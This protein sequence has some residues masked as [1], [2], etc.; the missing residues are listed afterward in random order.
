[1]EGLDGAPLAH[2]GP[3]VDVFRHGSWG[4]GPQTSQFL[5]QLSLCQAVAPL[6]HPLHEEGV[7]VGGVKIAAAPQDQGLADGVLEPVVALLGHAVFV[8]LTGID[9]GGA[10]PDVIEEGPVGVVQGPAAAAAHLVIGGR[11]IVAAHHLGD[12]AQG[13]QGVLQSLLQGQEGLAGDYLGVAPA[14]VAEYQLEQQVGER[15]AGDGHPQGVAVGKADLGLLSL[16][17]LLGEVDL[18]VR[19]MQCPPIL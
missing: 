15:L 3:A 6:D 14:R 16:G 2:P 8:A 19:S 10:Q 4:Q 17:M 11:G 9:A 18:A 13:P 1:M 7:V 12:S 5:L